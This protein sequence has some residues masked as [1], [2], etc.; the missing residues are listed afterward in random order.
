MLFFLVRNENV[1][2]SGDVDMIQETK[3]R[4]QA[5]L[6]FSETQVEEDHQNNLFFNYGLLAVGSLAVLFSQ[7]FL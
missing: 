3:L 4:K 6:D 5:F 1:Y 7:Y 2:K